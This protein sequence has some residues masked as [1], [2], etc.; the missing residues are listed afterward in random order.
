MWNTRL[1]MLVSF[2]Y[3]PNSTQIYLSHTWR[4]WGFPGTAAPTGQRLGMEAHPLQQEVTNVPCKGFFHE[5]WVF[6]GS[7]G[8][9]F[10]LNLVCVVQ[11]QTALAALML[12][13]HSVALEIQ[14]PFYF[15]WST[16]SSADSKAAICA[17]YAWIINISGLKFL[18]TLGMDC[19]LPHHRIQWQQ[20]SSFPLA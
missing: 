12:S 6:L 19:V 11:Y 1:L 5:L 17:V 15:H 2:M 13:Q 3:W 16:A 14:M 7:C 4:Q 18:C 9:T 20:R 8:R 10:L